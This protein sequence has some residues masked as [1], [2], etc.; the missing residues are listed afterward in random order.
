MPSPS[1]AIPMRKYEVFLSFSGQDIRHSFVSHLREALCQH[2]INTVV[3]ETLEKGEEISLTLMKKIE[4]SNI[5]VVIFSKSYVYSPW[6]LDELVKILECRDSMQQIVLPLFYHVDPEDFQELKGC[7]G[8]ALAKYKKE[9][10]NNSSMVDRWSHA[11]ME[12]AKITGWDSKNIKPESKLIKKIVNDIWKKLNQMSIN[13]F[14]H[15]LVGI[16]SRIKEVESLL[17]IRS[18][19]VHSLGIWGIGGI[20]KTTIAGVLYNRISAQFESQCFVANVRE[21]LEK[22]TIVHLR[23]EILSKLL[24]VDIKIGIPNVLPSFVK[25]MLLKKRVLIVLDDVSS[26]LQL[27]SLLEEHDSYGSGSRIIITSRNKQVLKYGCAKIYEVKE[28]IPHEAFQLFRFHALKQNRPSEAHVHLLER[29][30]NYAE[31]IPLALIVLGSNLCDKH[32]EEWESELVKLEGTPNKDIQNILRISYDGLDQNEKNIFLDVVCFFKGEDKD[33]VINILDSFGFSAKS[34]ISH[35][36]DKSLITISENK[37]EMHDLLQQMGKDI[38]DQEC[39]KQPGKRSRLWNYKD[40]YHVLT[41][42]K[43]TARVEGIILNMSQIRDM[44]L[45][46][47]VFM[48]MENLRFLKFFNPCSAKNKVYFPKGLKFLPDG[49][50]FLQWDGCPLKFLPSKFSPKNLIEFHMRESQLKRLWTEDQIPE[51]LQFVDLSHSMN[52]IR[53]PELSKFPKLKVLHLKDCT[54]LVEI[55]TS[56]MYD[57][58]LNDLNLENC[59]SLCRFPSCLFLRNLE[60]LTL[61]GCSKLASLPSSIGELKSLHYLD[62]QGCSNLASLPNGIGELKYLQHL[63]L[64]RCSQLGSLPSSICEL[65]C[66]LHLDLKECSKLVSLPIS[67]GELKCLK[68]LDL[69]GCSKLANLPVS[70]GKLKCENVYLNGCSKLASLPGSICNLKSL[71]RLDVT[72]CVNLKVLPENLGNLKSLTALYAVRSGIKELP[73]SINQ[74]RELRDLRCSGCKGL[75]LPPLTGLSSLEQIS[76]EGCGILEIPDSLGSLS[77]LHRLYLGGNNFKSIPASIKH[78]S[79]LYELDLR[80]CKRLQ[81]LPELP[82]AVRYLVASNCTSMKSVS[83]ALAEGCKDTFLWLDLGDCINLDPNARSKLMDSILLRFQSIERPWESSACIPG[84]QVPPGMRYKNNNGSSLILSMRAEPYCYTSDCIHIAFSA[85][86]ATHVYSSRDFIDIGCECC[87]ATESGQTLHFE[88]SWYDTS[89]A[90]G[91]KMHNVLIW[92]SA[93]DFDIKCRLSEASFQFYAKEEGNVRN[94]KAIVKCGV[95]LLFDDDVDSLLSSSRLDKIQPTSW[96]LKMAYKQ[97]FYTES[98]LYFPHFPDDDECEKDELPLQN[99]EEIDQELKCLDLNLS[100]FVLFTSMICPA[101]SR[102]NEAEAHPR[103]HVVFI[104]MILSVCLE[105]LSFNS[106]LSLHGMRVTDLN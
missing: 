1:S 49:L 15:G 67:I 85:V 30:M 88:S 34:G 95:H 84:S 102:H 51:N 77:T 14:N 78:L 24:G 3:D 44:E 11:L 43:G 58:K 91:S 50:T 99:L 100:I 55:S 86:V 8:D 74:L 54:S 68:H 33:R 59:K 69:K 19:G 96:V 42:D 70:I 52:L 36:N 16:D 47:T 26:P 61:K 9:F 93:Y 94:S 92:Y 48:K 22:H 56:L 76:L 71:T 6:C 63:D 2:Q 45:S 89:F 62:L 32:I 73:C 27:K 35:L 98:R 29:A 38:V 12:I 21:E 31:G 97:R 81:C 72:D 64:G 39:I 104:L 57:S 20:G 41:K 10:M 5:S 75:V 53:I 23:D 40:I 28:L 87:F 66:L 18:E 60:N 79:E 106:S 82:S 13:D 80:D 17:S 83:T 7:I 90:D 101:T 46:S 103:T 105:L 25:N 65:K 4:E 37:L